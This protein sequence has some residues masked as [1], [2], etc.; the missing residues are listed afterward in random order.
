M[1]LSSYKSGNPGGQGYNVKVVFEGD[2]W[3]EQLQQSFIDAADW[4]SSIIVGDL[5][6]ITADFGDGLGVRTIDDIEITATLTDIDGT[7]GILGQAGPG[8]YRTADYSVMTGSMEFDV[9]DA[10]SLADKTATGST[11]GW[12]EVV[13][14]EMLLTFGFGS[15]WGPMGL[16]QNIGTAEVPDYRFTGA[17]A[18]HEYQALFPDKYAADPNAAFG[19]PLESSSGLVGTDGSH[20]SE[21]FFSNELMTGFL[22]GSSNYLSNMTT[23]ALTDMGLAT[24]YVA[25]ALDPLCFGP[26]VRIETPAGPI[27]AKNLTVGQLVRVV[28]GGLLPI[29]SIDR[30]EMTSAR[31]GLRPNHRPILLQG[32][33]LGN[34]LPVKD[35][36]LSPQHRVAVN[37]PVLHRMTGHDHALV[38]AKDLLDLHGVSRIDDLSLITYYHIGLDRHEL[39]NAN[40]IEAETRLG[41]GQEPVLPVLR[42]AR[43]RKFVQ[44]SVK[45]H[46]ALVALTKPLR[47]SVA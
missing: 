17:N 28:G 33:A 27:A 26:D 34:G 1:L 47:Q 21:S 12:N 32:G 38:P 4:L 30:I 35:T 23:A 11:A 10:Q 15:M 24:T 39:V 5:S 16:I 7:G 18:M 43:A 20:W 46:R 40:G 3:T 41:K 8:F 31:L 45:N 42:G 2:L 29:R 37:G 14:H 13:L 44:R 36:I 25:S 6:N 19:V 22:N 9:A